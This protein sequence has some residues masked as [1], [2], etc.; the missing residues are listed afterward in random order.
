VSSSTDAASR[1][2]WLRVA[3]AVV[4]VAVQLAG[5]WVYR[6]GTGREAALAAP[7]AAT[8]LRWRPDVTGTIEWHGDQA[9]TLSAERGLQTIRLAPDTVV[10]RGAARTGL[11]ALRPGIPVSVWGPRAGPRGIAARA[12]LVWAPED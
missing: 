10:L 4:L 1:T 11:T 7:E 12:I 5:A 6:L 8:L 2:W 9:F 3:G